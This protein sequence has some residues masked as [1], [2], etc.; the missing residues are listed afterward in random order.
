MKTCDF[1]YHLPPELIAQIPLEPRD[2]SRLMILNRI[3]G[4][5]E[6]HRFSEIDTFLN[7]GDTLVFN[8]SRVIPARLTGLKSNSRARVELLLL[9][10][11]NSVTKM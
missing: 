9:L 1:D 4:S 8:D 11:K 7:S 10:Q 3:G 6:H 2:R 5:V